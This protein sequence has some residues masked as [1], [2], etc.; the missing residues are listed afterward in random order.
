M[1]YL[2]RILTLHGRALEAG[3]L[4]NIHSREKLRSEM[5][6]GVRVT[7]MDWNG[8]TGFRCQCWEFVC[9]FATTIIPMETWD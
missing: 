9:R 5:N 7:S 6:G 4:E 8:Q 2:R 1:T 3:S